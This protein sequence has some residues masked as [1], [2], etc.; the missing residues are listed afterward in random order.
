MFLQFLHKFLKVL[1]RA[2]N[3]TIQLFTPH[4]QPY[5]ENAVDEAVQI[6]KRQAERRKRG[7]DASQLSNSQLSRA[8]KS[9]VK[10]YGKMK[11]GYGESLQL[12]KK[13]LG[14]YDRR[15]SIGYWGT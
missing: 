10:T 7:M 6:G 3:I 13:L 14:E 4:T 15:Q 11:K 8:I 9:E 5:P 12:L 2:E 1:F